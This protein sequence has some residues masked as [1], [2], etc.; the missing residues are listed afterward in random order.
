MMKRLRNDE[1]GATVV[2][3]A[4]LLPVIF[5]SFL[6]VLQAGM[7][8]MTYNSLRN[9]SA[10]TSRYTLVEYQISNEL[11]HTQIEDDGKARAGS[12]GLDPTKFT[13]DVE[14]ATT[15]RIEGAT[16]LTLTTTYE[17]M[18][19]VSFLGVDKFDVSFTRPIF[20]IDEVDTS[21]DGSELD[22]T[23]DDGTGFGEGGI[24]DGTGGGGGETTDPVEGD[25]ADAGNCYGHTN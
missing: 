18:S 4:L 5:G 23:V 25:C 21:E 15:Q 24:D 1:S 19:V 12:H 7:S 11:T 9:L 17:V 2:E 20:L 3:F 6:G 14:T 8:M 10:E 22:G 13:I 16:E